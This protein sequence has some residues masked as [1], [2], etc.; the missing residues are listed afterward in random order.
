MCIKCL[1]WSVT[2]ICHIATC[3]TIRNNSFLKSL[4][5]FIISVLDIFVT[6]HVLQTT[7]PLPEPKSLPVPQLV[8]I[9]T[10]KITIP[11]HVRDTVRTTLLPHYYPRNYHPAQAWEA[12]HFPSQHTHP[13]VHILK[14]QIRSQNGSRHIW[15]RMAMYLDASVIYEWEWR[16]VSMDLSHMNL[17]YL[18][19]RIG[20]MYL[21]HMNVWNLWI[22]VGIHEFV[23]ITY[24][25]VVSDT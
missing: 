5:E 7:H 15:M 4:F 9:T 3:N 19:H 11:G 14:S 23:S 8:I 13:L 25:F 16:S 17:W 20:G 18:T 6:P 2:H 10:Q 24:E 12:R 21:S 1:T 22:C